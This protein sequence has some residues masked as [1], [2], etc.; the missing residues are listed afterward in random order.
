MLEKFLE[1]INP[2]VRTSDVLFYIFMI[3]KVNHLIDWSWWLI[4]LPYLIP[5]GIVLI[6]IL[7]KLVA[8][9]MEN[10]ETT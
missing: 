10:A 2:R 6:G 5:L 7:V 4:S 9:A 3:L 1:A 8:N